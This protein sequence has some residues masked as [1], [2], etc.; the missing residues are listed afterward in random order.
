MSGSSG[1]TRRNFLAM[2][3]AACVCTPTASQASG[4]KRDGWIDVH[5]HVFPSQYLRAAPSPMRKALEGIAGVVDW[6][7]EG[8]LAAMD[9]DGIRAAVLS[10]PTPRAWSNSIEAQREL[11][12]DVNEFYARLVAKYPRRFGM[13][14]SLPPL[15]DVDGA[16]VE[17]D[18]AYDTLAADG[19]R[20]MTV[21][22]DR[23]LGEPSFAPIWEALDRR[24]AAV[25]VHPDTGSCC[26]SLPNIAALELPLDTARAAA[27]L[28]QSGVLERW[29]HIRFILSHG[30]GA[31]PMIA[32]R[33]RD[34]TPL[35]G[36]PAEVREDPLIAF[37]VLSLD[38][39][40]AATP[41]A[42]NAMLALVGPQNILF[43]TDHPFVTVDRQIRYLR[44]AGL[45]E[46]GLTSLQH[47]NAERILKRLKTY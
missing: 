22:G 31:L 2:S 21:Y 17:I 18:Y 9:R 19:V 44:A 41:P 7:P 8:Q 10:F 29:P 34:R 33:L 36:E 45:P 1:S 46:S 4:E 39:A 24:N 47:R 20:V 42:L 15:T 13:F 38:T 27:S 35:V 3:A 43:G 6:T 11:A 26:S 5:N 12:R 14:A 23:W 28:W 25:F 30:G 40:N 32:G 37:R 16:L